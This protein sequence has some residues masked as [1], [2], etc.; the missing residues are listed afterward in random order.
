MNVHVMNQNMPP[1]EIGASYALY[2]P[3]WNGKYNKMHCILEQVDAAG[4]LFTSSEGLIRVHYTEMEEQECIVRK[5]EEVV[6]VT[7]LPF[8]KPV[9]GRVKA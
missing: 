7:G 9:A 5:L 1:W 4:V 2:Q 6:N 3:L 8:Y